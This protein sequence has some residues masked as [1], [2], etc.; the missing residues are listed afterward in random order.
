VASSLQHMTNSY[1]SSDS[2]LSPPYQ[3]SLL[4]LSSPSL[5]TPASPSVSLSNSESSHR[6][7]SSILSISNC[8]SIYQVDQSSSS[9]KLP[10]RRIAE[11][12]SRTRSSSESNLTSYNAQF[13]AEFS[14][15]E[16]PRGPEM[17]SELKNAAQQ[18]HGQTSCTRSNAESPEQ[19]E[20]STD[21]TDLQFSALSSDDACSLSLNCG[22]FL[23]QS[24]TPLACMSPISTAEGEIISYTLRSTCVRKSNPRCV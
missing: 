22:E 7:T 2:M 20:E 1:L 3:G 4:F 16:Q 11:L 18:L 6:R 24:A 23:R 13:F 9:I 10:A 14:P 8:N 19:S 15:L 5:E 21:C 17:T 12:S